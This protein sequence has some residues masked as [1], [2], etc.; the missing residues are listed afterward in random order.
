MVDFSC[1][2]V[3]DAKRSTQAFSTFDVQRYV[4]ISSDSCYN[5]SGLLLDSD[6]KLE[7]TDP[8][9]LYSLYDKF[10]SGIP[11]DQAVFRPSKSLK[12]LDD[13]GYDKL[14]AETHLRETFTSKLA[15]LRLPDVVGPFDETE[16][17]LKYVL[18]FTTPEF[19]EKHPIGFEKKDL[20]K[21]LSFVYCDDVTR[22]VMQCLRAS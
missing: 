11:E 16:R 7:T 18:W 8:D 4:Y 21:K 20:R 3:E 15:V 19:S 14:E 9:P 13:Y 22:V 1:Y 17:M 10:E 5:A 12:K 2:T 6:G